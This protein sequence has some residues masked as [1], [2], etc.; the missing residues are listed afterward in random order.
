MVNWKLETFTETCPFF[1]HQTF[2]ELL[3]S[4]AFLR[5]FQMS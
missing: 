2:R 1:N 3:L 5:R 4:G